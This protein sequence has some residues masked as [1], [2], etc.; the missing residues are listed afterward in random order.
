M[1]IPP[2]RHCFTFF[3]VLFLLNGCDII[4]HGTESVSRNDRTAEDSFSFEVDVGDRDLILLDA[5]NGTIELTGESNRQFVSIRGV[6]IVGSES[7]EDAE[8]HLSDLEVRV[9]TTSSAVRVNTEQPED[10][11]GRRYIVNYEIL[12]PTDW[13]S[14]IKQINGTIKVDSLQD[15]T[16][17]ALI[18]G[19]IYMND[20][21]ANTEVELVNGTIDSKITVPTGGFLQQSIVNGKIDLAIPTTTSSE[22]SARLRNGEISLNNLQLNQQTIEDNSVTGKLGDGNGTIS[23]NVTNGTIDVSGF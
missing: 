6:R 8:A 11:A 23:L 15:E 2:L 1:C 13:R 9:T 19:D 7:V 16:E 10:E 22:F 18:N 12:L 4:D 17:I 20:I 3:L 14:N 21:N 5:V